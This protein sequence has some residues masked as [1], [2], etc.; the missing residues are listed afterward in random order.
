MAQTRESISQ[1]SLL[2]SG[3]EPGSGAEQP[4]ASCGDA[5]VSTH[6]RR[7]KSQGKPA[8]TRELDG[9]SQAF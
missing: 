3:A 7:G 9:K 5:P 2:S 4:G 8:S 1:T 6:P